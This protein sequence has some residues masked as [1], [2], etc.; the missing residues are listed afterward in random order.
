MNSKLFFSWSSFSPALDCKGLKHWV[1]LKGLKDK[2]NKKRFQTRS[3]TIHT[4][5]SSEASR[6]DA[7]L[8]SSIILQRDLILRLVMGGARGSA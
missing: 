1:V 8:V 5:A 6:Q 3:V 7:Y 2:K 4:K